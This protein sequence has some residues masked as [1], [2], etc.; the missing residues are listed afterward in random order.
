M[1]KITLALTVAYAVFELLAPATAYAFGDRK[2][3]R[4]QRSL[5]QPRQNLS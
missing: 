1:K 3:Q 5:S 4:S 2:K